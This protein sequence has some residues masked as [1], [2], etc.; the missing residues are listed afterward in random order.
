[1]S[2]PRRDERRSAREVKRDPL[3]SF[4]RELLENQTRL[5]ADIEK[6]L[7]EHAW[8]L[9]SRTDDPKTDVGSGD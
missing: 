5:P 8:E 6:M 3:A 2:K 7:D 1:M 4:E 9:Y